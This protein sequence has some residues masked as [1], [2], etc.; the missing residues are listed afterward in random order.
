MVRTAVGRHARSSGDLRLSRGQRDPQHDGAL[1]RRAAR[2]GISSSTS[3]ASDARRIR[4]FSFPTRVIRRRNISF[5]RTS[6]SPASTSTCTISATSSAT[7]CACK[8][9]RKIGRSFWANSGWIRSATREEEQA[10]MLGWHVDSVVKCGL[11]GTVFFAWTDEW[12]TGDQEIT[13][14]AFGIVTRDARAEEVILRLARKSSDRTTR[15]SRIA[16]CRG[17]RS[18]PSSSVPTTAAKTL[19]EC[20]ESL[21]KLNYPNLR[22]H[23]GRRRI[24]RRHT[25]NRRPFPERPLHPSDNHGLS[26]ARNAGAAAAKGEVLRLHRLGLHGRSGLALLS[27]RA[28]S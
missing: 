23:P 11:A 5:R 19:A 21:G 4:T 12:F 7:C 25:G 20:L 18:S 13:D 22:S 2:D 3:F 8:I 26:H 24:D 16:R 27:R 15:R 1:A 9:S 14:W 6:I 10:E 17:R 28:R